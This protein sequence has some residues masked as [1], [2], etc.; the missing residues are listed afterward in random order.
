MHVLGQTLWKRETDFE[1]MAG[2]YFEA[3][4]ASRA[5]RVRAMMQ[6]ARRFHPNACGGSGPSGT[7]PW[8]R[9]TR[10]SGR[11][12]SGTAPGAPNRPMGHRASRPRCGRP[13]STGVNSARPTPHCLE[14]WARGLEDECEIR[15]AGLRQVVRIGE[16]AHQEMLD[17]YWFL[18]TLDRTVLPVL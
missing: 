5:G 15:L 4:F 10:R 18:K 2:A 13:L 16:P 3:L 6:A 1:A 11:T 14:A 7:R 8:R 9:I 12:A 17:V